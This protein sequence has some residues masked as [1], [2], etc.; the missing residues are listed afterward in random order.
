MLAQRLLT[1]EATQAFAKALSD[2]MIAQ[3]VEGTLRQRRDDL[4]VELAHR[5]R[6]ALHKD[7]AR[8]MALV[9]EGQLTEVESWLGVIGRFIE[10][11]TFNP[12]VL[13]SKPT[14]A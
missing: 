11:G 9:L 7:E 10:S 14:T 8:A 4:S 12:G 2:P 1:P 3:A 13:K 6:V 5:S